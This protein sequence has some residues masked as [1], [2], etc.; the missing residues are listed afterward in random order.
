MGFSASV[1]SIN[2]YIA[3]GYRWEL[4][5]VRGVTTPFSFD[6]MGMGSVVHMGLAS[7]VGVSNWSEAVQR[8]ADRFAS[9]KN[10]SDVAPEE[11]DK[12][13]LYYETEAQA[14]VK[15]MYD[16]LQLG[17]W[18]PAIVGDI[19]AV[20]YDFSEEV[21]PGIVFNGV[22]DFV[23]VD[24][25]GRTVLLDWKTTRSKGLKGIDNS[26]LIQ[27]GMYNHMLR[28]VFDVQVNT[29]GIMRIKSEMPARATTML[30]KRSLIPCTQDD[31]EAWY[32]LAVDIAREMRDNPNT[33][34]H[35]SWG[36]CGNCV[37]AE[38]CRHEIAGGNIAD[39]AFAGWGGVSDIPVEFEL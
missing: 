31:L 8:F 13:Q 38:M 17:I 21:E 10:E 39:F 15:R 12:F 26:Y 34:R 18:K 7:V 20:E 6:K 27:L 28:K 4:F 36:A 5:R 14:I 25:E 11:L 23:G 32:N 22:I 9:F 29:V 16:E 1:S 35:P 2:D 19:Q 37:V 3:C 30:F 33:R 24:H